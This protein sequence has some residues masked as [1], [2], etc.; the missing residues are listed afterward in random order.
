VTPDGYAQRLARL[1][2]RVGANVAPGQDVFVLA[3]AVEQ[4]PAA[5]LVAEEAYRAGARFVSVIYWDDEVK[6]ARLRHA[7]ADSL[8][9]EPD[10]W[11]R[12]VAECVERRGAYIMLWGGSA[13]DLFDGV[14]PDRL[15]ADLMPLTGDVMSAF[16]GG[17]V[18]WTCVPAPFSAVAERLLGS[19]DLERMWQI[20][21]PILR[22]DA[23]DPEAAWQEHLARLEERAGRLAER[24]F[25]ELHFRGPG[26]D[27][28]IGL[29]PS[30][31]WVSGGITTSWGQRTVA[32]MP[33]EEVFTTP[34]NRRA[35]GQVRTTRPVQLLSGGVA[36][37]VE[38]RLAGGRIVEV[39][40]TR[41]E[42]AVR[43]QIASDPGASRLG[44][45]ALVDGSSPV[46]RSG[47]VFG[48]ALIDENAASHM[49]WGSAYPFTMP[50]LPTSEPEQDAIGFNRSSV[51]QDVMIGG[52]EVEVDGIERGGAR[53]PIIRDDA[54]VLG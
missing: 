23:S 32:N 37:D 43:A 46:G 47:V 48:D 26:T 20:L 38:V 49:A 44:E 7:P 19:P 40:A 3:T 28:R 41:G 36:E 16:G 30:A 45:I 1:A 53:V 24:G 33:T 2:V 22:L 18:N 51:H 6:R 14:A 42:E 21:A 35:E 34:D 27:L 50:E 12:H 13:P 31:R 10:W 9:F 4:A 17:E 11:R 29:I 54:W 25:D 8:G 39:R 5:R 52:L 15:G